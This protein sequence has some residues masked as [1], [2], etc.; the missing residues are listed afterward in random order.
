[1]LVRSLRW[2]PPTTA[3][4]QRRTTK[5]LNFWPSPAIGLVD[6]RILERTEGKNKGALYP[7]IL[8]L[9]AEALRPRFGKSQL[10]APQVARWR[11]NSAPSNTLPSLRIYC[12]ARSPRVAPVATSPM[13]T[14]PRAKA[15]KLGA[16]PSRRSASSAWRGS[17]ARGS[18]RCASGSRW[19]FSKCSTG[20]ANRQCRVAHSF[21]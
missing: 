15:M 12:R 6:G 11:S 17:R 14:V 8:G 13:V 20:R 4:L 18:R 3:L 9:N 10:K 5:R 19:G 1:M 16:S 2:V 7:Y 21:L